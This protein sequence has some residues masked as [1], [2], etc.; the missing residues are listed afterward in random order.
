MGALRGDVSAVAAGLLLWSFIVMAFERSGHYGEAAVFTVVAVLVRAY[1]LVLPGMKEMRAV[2]QWAAGRA[3]D[4]TTVLGATYAYARRAV[5]RTVG[6]DAVWTAL[7]T[8]G[9]GAIAGATGSRLVQYAIL[10]P[11]WAWPTC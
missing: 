3:A 6:T 1:L 10:A 4:P 8:V 9:V 11:R 2:E 5:A 7:F